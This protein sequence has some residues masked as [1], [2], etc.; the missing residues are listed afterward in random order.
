MHVLNPYRLASTGPSI[1]PDELSNLA[2][3]YDGTDSSSMSLDGSNRVLSITDKSANAEVAVKNV[4]LSGSVFDGTKITFTPSGGGLGASTN[5]NITSDIHGFIVFS[6]WDASSA[7]FV[8]RSA[9]SNRL[10]LG[11]KD[12]GLIGFTKYIGSWNT[13]FDDVATVTDEI[14]ILEFKVISNTP[15]GYLNDNALVYNSATGVPT[16]T[17]NYFN[18]GG[19]SQYAAETW[20]FYECFIS[21]AEL[22]TEERD[23]ILNYLANKY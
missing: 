9:S 19:R 22:T 23:G 18:L 11:R 16:A 8:N 6:N 5:N 2:M 12:I 10:S 21:D 4:S 7:F 13:A 14:W 20:D 1:T 3:W 17:G 15:T